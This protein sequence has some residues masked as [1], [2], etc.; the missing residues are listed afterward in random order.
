MYRSEY[1]GPFSYRL[2]HQA[3]PWIRLFSHPEHEEPSLHQLR[4]RLLPLEKHLPQELEDAIFLPSQGGRLDQIEGG[5]SLVSGPRLEG[6]IVVKLQE[7]ELGLT[8]SEV[9]S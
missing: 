5:N 7:H 4:H 9:E 3:V 2:F 1:E 8:I 6:S